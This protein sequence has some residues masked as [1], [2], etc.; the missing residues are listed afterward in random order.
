MAETIAERIVHEVAAR[1]F[2]WQGETL[3]L[4][5]SIGESTRRGED[6]VFEQAPQLASS[7]DIEYSNNDTANTPSSQLNADELQDSSPSLHEAVASILEEADA[8][9]Y[10]AKRGVRNTLMT[11]PMASPL[12]QSP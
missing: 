7:N 1:P 11:T 2:Q 6:L 3:P 4:S 10:V 8:A 5:V 12:L 9:L